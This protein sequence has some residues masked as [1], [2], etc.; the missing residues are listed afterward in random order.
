MKKLLSVL[1]SCT[2]MLLLAG[3][4]GK[5]ADPDFRDMSAY[6][7]QDGFADSLK[8][9]YLS[10]RKKYPELKNDVCYYVNAQNSMPAG[11]EVKVCFTNAFS[12]G[13]REAGALNITSS[14][15]NVSDEQYVFS[16][17]KHFPVKTVMETSGFNTVDEL[18]T[19]VGQVQTYEELGDFCAFS[20]NHYNER[21]VYI[22]TIYYGTPGNMKSVDVNF[23]N[24]RQ[25]P[26]QSMQITENSIYYYVCDY[27]DPERSSITVVE[28]PRN[29]GEVTKKQ[30]LLAGLGLP[31][32]DSKGLIED[33]FA[34]GGCLFMLGSFMPLDKSSEFEFYITVYDLV[35]DKFDV[36]HTNDFK[37]MGKLFRYDDGL[38][39]TTAVYD[40][41]GYFSDMGVR[42][43]NF[44]PKNC[45]L[46]FNKDISFAQSK[47]WAYDMGLSEREFYCIDGM[48][49]G[50]LT[51]K[52][53]GAMLMYV[54]IDLRT[55][56]V[57]TCVPFAKNDSKQTK[58]WVFGSVLIRDNGKAVSQHNCS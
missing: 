21:P 13:W 44:D 40:E 26:D 38:G 12:D 50:V 25:P 3:C 56:E 15:I 48:L 36:Y 51:Y 46:S 29:G 43:L 54:E 57:T 2:L 1:L 5:A 45:K 30:L 31:V 20:V 39:V 49:C 4:R 33:I 23:G 35:T 19:N 32:L 28:I 14:G 6:D 58:G 22:D 9:D 18:F 52:A 55:G 37:G 17:G 27:A 42:F 53:N 10:F 7:E 24:L 47:D 11:R 8:S 34:D 16:F 41:K